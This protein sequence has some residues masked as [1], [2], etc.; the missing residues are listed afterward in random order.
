MNKRTRDYA[1]YAEAVSADAIDSHDFKGPAFVVETVRVIREYERKP[2][3]MDGSGNTTIGEAIDAQI[4]ETLERGE[5]LLDIAVHF[6]RSDW[7]ALAE[8]FHGPFSARNRS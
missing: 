3:R 6:E 8:S 4:R 2:I 5:E 1:E 7:T